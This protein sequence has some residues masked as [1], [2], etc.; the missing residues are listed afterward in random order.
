MADSIILAT[1]RLTSALV[2]TQDA[3]FRGLPGIRF[4]D[5]P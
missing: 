2:W 5:I 3:H 1:A 4:F